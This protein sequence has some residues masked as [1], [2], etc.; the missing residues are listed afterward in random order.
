[1]MR[2]TII[3]APTHAA[4]S[5]TTWF[6]YNNRKEVRIVRCT[7]KAI[8]PT[9][10][11]TLVENVSGGRDFE[12]WVTTPA[13]LATNIQPHHPRKGPARSSANFPYRRTRRGPRPSA[14][15]DPGMLLASVPS[16]PWLPFVPDLPG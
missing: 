16:A 9:P 8:E 14:L 2:V 5:P 10:Y 12:S 3:A 6:K 13:L 1:M 7:P 11:R 15:G 4:G